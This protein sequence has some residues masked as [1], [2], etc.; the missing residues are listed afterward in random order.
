MTEDLSLKHSPSIIDTDIDITNVED[1]ITT[2]ELDYSDLCGMDTLLRI[3]E[4]PEILSCKHCI[5]QEMIID[6]DVVCPIRVIGEFFL[7]RKGII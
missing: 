1:V 5:F 6:D 7:T 3:D 2:I 4:A